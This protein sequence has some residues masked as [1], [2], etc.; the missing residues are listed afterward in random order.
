MNLGK[1]SFVHV[2]NDVGSPFMQSNMAQNFDQFLF[3][4][5]EC[6]NSCNTSVHLIF[7]NKES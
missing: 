7:H 3:R 2:I 6:S 4:D 5:D 1:G